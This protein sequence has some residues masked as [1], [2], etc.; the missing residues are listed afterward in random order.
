MA[1]TASTVE[2]QRPPAAPRGRVLRA[3]T[4]PINTHAA[5]SAGALGGGRV[6]V[7]V[8]SEHQCGLEFVEGLS[9]PRGC[10]EPAG[11]A[12]PPP[13]ER[14][15]LRSGGAARRT[16]PPAADGD[17]GRVAGDFTAQGFEE[18]THEW[19]GR[20]SVFEA[21]RT[22]ESGGSGGEEIGLRR[23]RQRRAKQAEGKGC[24]GDGPNAEDGKQ[25]GEPVATAELP[26]HRRLCRQRH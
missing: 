15:E 20:L 22:G 4:A 24:R 12:L 9:T 10:V 11:A 8:M 14:D 21:S 16:A 5:L 2:M 19:F 26:R 7:V 6:G 13:H 17:E 1:R 25:R 23:R 3:Q 18:Q